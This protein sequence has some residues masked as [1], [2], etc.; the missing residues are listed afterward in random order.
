[1]SRAYRK[2]IRAAKRRIESRLKKRAWREQSQPMCK[3]SNIH[4]EM[5]DQ[6]GAIACGGIG[7]VH[8]LARRIGLLDAI[9]DQVHVLKRHLPYHESDHVLNFALNIL[10][11]GERIEDMEV[12]R[13]DENFLNALGAQRLPDPTTA[14]DFTRRFAPADILCLQEAINTARRNVWK[15]QPKDFLAEAVIDVDGSVAGTLGE[16]KVGMDISYK[17]SG[18]ITRS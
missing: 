11:G 12:R 2:I 13:Q 18:D 10:A 16:C 15:Q 8:L 14:G 6:T 1:M 5:S 3:G 9:D 17:G 4:Y 7:M